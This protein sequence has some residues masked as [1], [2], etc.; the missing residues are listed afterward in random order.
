MRS[1]VSGCACLPGSTAL[2]VAALEGLPKFVKL[3]LSHGAEVNPEVSWKLGLACQAAW[4]LVSHCTT[5][6]ELGANICIRMHHMSLEGYQAMLYIISRS[7]NSCFHAYM[8][9]PVWSATSSKSLLFVSRE[10]QC[11]AMQQVEAP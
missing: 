7:V 10:T 4:L 1:V 5:H 9:P 6:M 3:L 11:S 2:T 8:P